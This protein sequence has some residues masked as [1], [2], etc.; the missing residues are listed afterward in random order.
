LILDQLERFAPGVRERVIASRS[1]S[2]AEFA[3]YNPNFRGGDILT[4]ANDARQVLMRPRP[5]LNPY[6][7]GIDGVYICSAA[8]PPGAGAHGM[9]GHNAALQFLDGLG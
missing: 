9:C 7:T 8:T 6:A 4:G 5:A 2:P 1:R 3:A